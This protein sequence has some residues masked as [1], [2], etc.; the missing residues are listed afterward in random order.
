[1]TERAAG[2]SG[3]VARGRRLPSAAQ[4]AEGVLAGNRAMLARAI[5]FVESSSDKHRALA[6]RLLNELTPHTGGA[7]RVG[8]TGV[9]GVGKSTFI[10]RLGTWLTGGAFGAPQQVAVL[11]IDPSSTVSRG[12]ILG[13]KT[14]MS[15]LSSDP[16]AFVRPSPSSGTLG[17]V[18]RKTRETLL[19]CEAAGFDVVLVETVGVGQSETIITE[20]T[21]FFLVLMLPGAGDELQGIKRGLLELADLVAV[22]KADGDNVHAARRAAAEHAAAM[23]CIARADEHWTPPVLLCSAKTG[24]GVKEV[25]DAVTRRVG[26]LRRSGRLEEIR[27]GQTVSWMRQLIADRLLLTFERDAAVAGARERVEAAVRD[28]R[29]HPSAAADELLQTFLKKAREES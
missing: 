5:S 26:E 6:E 4:L 15:S 25:W 9:P 8:I 20:M 13:D 21:D 24:D 22:N 3:H 16:R 18:A 10:E 27:H 14:R 2:P 11:A 1:M 29:L 12:S 23:R 7:L 28:A 19:L 17:G